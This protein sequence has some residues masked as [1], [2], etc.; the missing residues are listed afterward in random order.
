MEST[1]HHLF[2]ILGAMDGASRITKGLKPYVDTYNAAIRTAE[3]SIHGPWRHLVVDRDAWRLSH[4]NGVVA[5]CC[6]TSSSPSPPPVPALLCVPSAAGHFLFSS[7][8]R[9]TPSSKKRKSTY[10]LRASWRSSPDVAKAIRCSLLHAYVQS[11]CLS[12]GEGKG[13]GM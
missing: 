9:N 2:G 1:M 10:M 5:F 7:P 12:V 6:S 4:A 13:E 8:R 3:R 11:I